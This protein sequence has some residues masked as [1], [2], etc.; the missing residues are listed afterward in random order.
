MSRGQ[1][2]TPHGS[3]G[4]RPAHA[5]TPEHGAWPTRGRGAG[6]PGPTR[7]A[8]HHGAGRERT[9][10]NRPAEAAQLL[11]AS[12]AATRFHLRPGPCRTTPTRGAVDGLQGSRRPASRA[13]IARALHPLRPVAPCGTPDLLRLRLSAT[14]RARPPVRLAASP[15]LCG[16]LRQPELR[17][18]CASGTPRSRGVREIPTLSPQNRELS[19]KTVRSSPVASRDVPN[20]SPESGAGRHRGAYAMVATG[21]PS[22][23]SPRR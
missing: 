14:P 23:P 1:S 13:S 19:P 20:L 21:G 11:G 18:A 2:T 22:T 4:R 12:P 9:P 3:V 7:G 16:G 17:Q 10:S 5:G 6:G 8:G 15:R